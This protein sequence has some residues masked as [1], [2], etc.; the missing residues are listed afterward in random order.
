MTRLDGDVLERLAQE[1]AHYPPQR[2]PV[3][4]AT[5]QFHLG[6][7]LANA[8]RTEQ[9]E[10]ALTAAADLF[11]EHFPVERAKVLN[12]L[13]ATLRSEGRHDRARRCFEQAA[14]MFESRDMATERAAALFNLGLVCKDMGDLDSSIVAFRRARDDFEPKA[15]PRPASDA[16][17]EL[18]AALLMGGNPDDAARV[19]DDAES[20]ADRANDAAARGAAANTLGLAHL[21]A[22]RIDDAV[23]ALGR[24][25]V[26]HP[27]S[28]RPESYAMAKANLAAAYERSGRP[29][30]AHVAARHAVAV[31]GAPEVVVEQASGIKER[32]DAGR[33]AVL[34]ILDDEPR[35]RWAAVV[36]DE[37]AAWLGVDAGERRAEI[38]GWIHGHAARRDAAEDLAETLLGVLLELPPDE[39]T[40]IVSAIVEETG[41]HADTTADAFRSSLAR[42]MVRFHPPQ[43]SRLE[44]TFNTCARR[45]DEQPSWG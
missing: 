41:R 43:W 40:T 21:A 29:E 19:L 28:I 16:A 20:L 45:L 39:M 6:V 7:A 42:A 1:A 30:R 23:A 33:G 44:Q 4:H 18:G 9:A 37:V 10:G 17:R 13:G 12:A 38:G 8:G 24:A 2:Y 22:D 27:R 14:R 34:E 35:D 32:V 3:Q 31:P 15:E 25:I 11:A 36:R 26:A 5:A